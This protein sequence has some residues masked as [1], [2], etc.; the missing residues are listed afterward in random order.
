MTNIPEN[1][2]G[3]TQKSDV[4]RITPAYARWLHNGEV[5]RLCELQPGNPGLT[6]VTTADGRNFL[7]VSS[8]LVPLPARKL[9]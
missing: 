5:V 9:H 1:I 7:V 2:P 4:A 3:F 6:W 8:Q